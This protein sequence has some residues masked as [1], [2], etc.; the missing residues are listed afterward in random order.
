MVKPKQGDI[1]WVSSGHSGDSG[2][3]G[4]RPAVVIQNDLLNARNIRTTVVSLITSNLK[5]R[6][7]P[8][9]VSLKKGMGNIHK[10][11][12][13][14]VSQVTTIDKNRL[15]EKVG[16]LDNKTVDEILRWML[17]VDQ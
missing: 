2:P 16:S 5:L 4:K 15:I 12:V 14:V 7:V 3:L 8:G 1:Y 6:N 17:Y 10:S 11:S 9:N 13:V